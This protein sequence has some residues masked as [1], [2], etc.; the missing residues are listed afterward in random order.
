MAATDLPGD[1]DGA[2]FEAAV[3]RLAELTRISSP[4]TDPAGLAAFAEHF[5]AELS[6][7]G[8]A[9]R[10]TATDGPGGP[11][12][13]LVAETPSD[14]RGPLL[15]LGHIDTVLP[16]TV[17]RR[18]RERLVATGA[19]DMKGGLA[20]LLA[21]LDLLQAR[22]QPPPPGLRLVLAPDEEIG[23]EIS[24]RLTAAEGVAARAVWVLEPG[25]PAP[26]GGET[27]VLGRR[28]LET[29]RLYVRGRSAHSGLQFAQGRSALVA[30]A[31]WAVAAAALSRAGDGPTVN[32]A[33]LV[34]GDSGFVDELAANAAL[35]GR[36]VQL[37]V[38]PDRA[39]VEGEFR[40][41]RAEDRRAVAAALGAAADAV[42]AQRDVEA[43]LEFAGEIPPVP[44]TAERRAVAGRAVDLA[45]ARGWRLDVETERG[46]VSFPNFLQAATSVPVLDGLGPVG[47]GMHTREEFVDLRSYARRIV[48]LA[49]LLAADRDTAA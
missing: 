37:N 43:R 24:R 46:G 39:V 26:D 19:I 49:D 8:L 16:A 17:P 7:R 10:L 34:A 4:S 40:F 36:D 47:G 48:L 12:P 2:A 27:I 30:A 23:G 25:E 15:L 20:T 38:V 9:P 14:G 44:A 6:R 28:G 1:L 5:A 42:A 22:Q 29:F 45:G 35:L 21:A 31:E 3:E 32:P 13:V 11:L 41:L 33:R 18:D